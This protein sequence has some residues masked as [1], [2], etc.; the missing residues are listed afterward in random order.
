VRHKTICSG[1]AG[2][3][4]WCKNGARL[5]CVIYSFVLRPAASLDPNVALLSGVPSPIL[6]STIA[7]GPHQRSQS[8][9]GLPGGPGPRICILQGQDGPGHYSPRTG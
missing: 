9:A 8:P 4:A 6:S 1:Q 3:V 2:R 5:S 7:D